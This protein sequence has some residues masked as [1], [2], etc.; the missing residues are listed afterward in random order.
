MGLIAL[1]SIVAVLDLLF[2]GMI[3]E[4]SDTIRSSNTLDSLAAGIAD[5]PC[6]NI[7]DQ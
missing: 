1:S 2:P 6:D 7:K 5:I 3:A 4:G